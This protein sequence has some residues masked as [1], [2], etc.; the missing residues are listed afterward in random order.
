MAIVPRWSTVRSASR[1][2]TTVAPAFEMVY[3]AT[4][5]AAT[6]SVA[7][8][9]APA[10]GDLAAHLYRTSLVQHGLLVWDNLWFGGQYPLASY[11]LLY[12]P[13]A[14]VVGNTALGIAGVVASAAL[15]SSL[16]ERE[17]SRAGRWPARIFALLLAGQAFTAAYPYDVGVASMLA[18]LWALQRGRLWLVSLFTVL[19]VLVSPLA[20]VFLFLAVSAVFVRRFRVNRA[21][22]WTAAAIVVACAVEL[23][24]LIGLPSPEG[25][26]P[27]GTWRLLAGLAVVAPGVVLAL[28]GRGGWRLASLF[29]IWAA[30]SVLAYGIPSPIGHNLVRVSVFLVPLILVA[31]ALAD[32][33]PRW[34]AAVALAGALAAN[35]LPYLPMVSQRTIGVDA[36]RTYWQPLIGYLRRHLAP[37]YRVEVVPTANHWESYYLPAAGIPLARGWYRQLDIAQ[38]PILYGVGLGPRTYP[39]WLRAYAVRFVVVANLPLEAID[40][41]RE[42]RIVESPRSGLRLVMRTRSFDVYELPRPTPL[43]TGPGHPTVTRFTGD[44]IAATTTRAGTY[45]LRVHYTPYWHVAGDVCVGAAGALTRIRVRRPGPFALRAIESPLALLAARI[46]GD[47]ATTCGGDVS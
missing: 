12:Y 19:T 41:V 22:L 39:T 32:Y 40:A 2:S 28:R 42:A 23:G 43:L 34:L 44:A 9:V 13:L 26:Y 1:R 7:V 11:S 17:W 45:L 30:A 25:A 15:F 29:V 47:A 21:V 35:V 36:R 18:A 27:Y 38:N 20:F 16:L 46:D 8:F 4:L 24:V 31:A 10:G 6:S 14:A 33:R 3:C 37:G 5:A